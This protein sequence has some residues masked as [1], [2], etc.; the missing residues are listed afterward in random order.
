MDEKTRE[1]SVGLTRTSSIVVAFA[2]ERRASFQPRG[3]LSFV[4]KQKRLKTLKRN[5]H[6][7]KNRPSILLK[8]LVSGEKRQRLKDR[9]SGETQ[10]R[11]NKGDELDNRRVLP[12]KETI[13]DCPSVA[14]DENEMTASR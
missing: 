2:F 1:I 8:N 10:F 7:E 6:E 5:Q 3:S 9:S 11:A 12:A 13:V 4:K 14:F